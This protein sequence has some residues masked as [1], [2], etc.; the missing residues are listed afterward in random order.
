MLES[1]TEKCAHC[2]GTGHVRSVSSV[3]LQLLRSLEEMLLKGATHNLTVRTRAEIALY[4]LN[5][6]RAHLRALEE[7]FRITIMV[8]AD[9]A[10]GGQLSFVIERGEQVHS[11]EG[12][13][14]GIAA[15]DRRSRSP[16]SDEEGRRRAEEEEEEA[17]GED[18]AA[19]PRRGGEARRRGAGRRAKAASGGRR[20]RGRRG[21]EGRAPAHGAR[22]EAPEAQGGVRRSRAATPTRMPE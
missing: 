2:G 20:R 18:A 15:G 11:L 14:A 5:H 7:R 3:A 9:A 21:G 19:A 22:G 6:K 4:L 8:N 16:R 12:Q 17:A 1:S 10:I 13:G